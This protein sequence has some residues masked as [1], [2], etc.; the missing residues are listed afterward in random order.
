M[1]K[2]LKVVI[3]KK[4]YDVTED[5]DCSKDVI[6]AVRRRI[7]GE[8]AEF[9]CTIL[10]MTGMYKDVIEKENL[11]TVYDDTTQIFTGYLEEPV[12]KHDEN[13]DRF[14]IVA[15]SKDIV[16]GELDTGTRTF[17]N[18]YAHEILQGWAGD[19]SFSANVGTTGKISLVSD[20][21]SD[22]MR[23]DILGK[24]GIFTLTERITLNGTTEVETSNSYSDLL[25]VELES[26]A[27]GT[28]TIKDI[29]DTTLGTISATTTNIT[30]TDS[31]SNYSN[32][33]MYGHGFALSFSRNFEYQI[34]NF[35][36]INEPPIA[37]IGRLEE[38][39]DQDPTSSDY[40]QWT[41]YLNQSTDTL[42]FLPKEAGATNWN[43]Y[44]DV[45]V[46]FESRIPT[47][48]GVIL[49]GQKVADEN[50]IPREIVGYASVD[51]GY[52]IRIY[53]GQD[54][55]IK[56]EGDIEQKA[57]AI[58]SEINQS[59]KYG[60]VY[61]L[62]LNLD[63]ELYDTITVFNPATLEWS[64]EIIFEIEDD[65]ENGV[66]NLRV[67][68]RIPAFSSI[69]VLTGLENVAVYGNVGVES[70]MRSH[71]DT[72]SFAN[73]LSA[74][75]NLEVRFR[76]EE[77]GV[78]SVKL[79]VKGL[80]YLQNSAGDHDHSAGSSYVVDSHDHNEG[81]LAGDSHHHGDGTLDV[82][83]HDHSISLDTVA[84]VPT[85]SHNHS[86]DHDHDDTFA[87]DDHDATN[88]GYSSQDPPTYTH[89]HVVY[90]YSHTVTGGVTS[91]SG[92]SGL[93]SSTTQ[94]YV[95]GVSQTATGS[96][97]PDVGGITGNESV[98]V[99]G[100]T[101][102]SGATISG[103][104]GTTKA[105]PGLLE[106]NSYPDNMSIFIND[107]DRTAALGG[108]WG[109]GT[110]EL[111]IELDITSYCSADGNYTIKFTSDEDG[112]LEGDVTIYY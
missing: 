18:K 102:G 93:P 19:N 104:S 51:D 59:D 58:L 108:P 64:N 69:Q 31:D 2:P 80:K 87:V 81:S 76:I 97:S 39:G 35:K 43:E 4:I 83:S 112:R 8:C 60:Y 44:G 13:G 16:L 50:G 11:I 111:D 15:Y 1:M 66:T 46:H 33:I 25:Y 40:I 9:S 103:N 45:P 27:V 30:K 85:A 36:V 24:N 67:G 106:I 7:A 38:M 28:I 98:T 63:I 12:V 79:R 56:E 72:Y 20:N 110:T 96:R 77:E 54:N 94:Y 57:E 47:Y 6:N 100:T 23:A 41:H 86:I 55:S 10:D 5:V 37:T 95:G 73:N 68:H 84:G 22:T 89:T 90:S 65:F 62:P 29:D 32:G 75:R 88:T 53:R 34:E 70:V 42:T 78:S 105:Q 91:H 107:I 26:A 14:D 61:D 71:H 109:D 52:R 82:D 3:Q 21:A 101:G 92:N 49:K 48:N 99:T 17:L 74:D